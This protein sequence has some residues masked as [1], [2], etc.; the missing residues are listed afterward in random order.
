VATAGPVATAGLVATAGAV[1]GLLA[2]GFDATGFAAGAWGLVPALALDL[3]FGPAAVLLGPCLVVVREPLPVEALFLDIRASL[4]IDRGG[5]KRRNARPY[6]AGVCD[7]C[8]ENAALPNP[9]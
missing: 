7:P 3:A 5:R 4:A 9:A 1:D 8:S 6:A 2:D